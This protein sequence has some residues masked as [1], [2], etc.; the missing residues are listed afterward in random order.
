MKNKKLIRTILLYSLYSI[1]MIILGIRIAMTHVLEG[2]LLVFY[3]ILA[4]V[5]IYVTIGNGIRIYRD[6]KNNQN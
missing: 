3:L 2:P 6:Y 5:H 4:F 1:M